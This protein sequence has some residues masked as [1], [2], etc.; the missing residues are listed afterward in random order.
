MY[1]D[2]AEKTLRK[3]RPLD[4]GPITAVDAAR[5]VLVFPLDLYRLI[6]REL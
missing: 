1:R 2:S 5:N 6:G 4:E 3:K